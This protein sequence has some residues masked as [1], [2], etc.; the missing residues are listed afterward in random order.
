MYVLYL[1]DIA[2]KS[3]SGLLQVMVKYDVYSI[4]YDYSNGKQQLLWL[5]KL[6]AVLLKTKHRYSFFL[7]SCSFIFKILENEIYNNNKF[8]QLVSLTN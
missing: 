8:L 5:Q 3:M 1:V 2:L 7:T 4:S 6:V